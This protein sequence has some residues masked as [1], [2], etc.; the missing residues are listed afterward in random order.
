MKDYQS[1]PNLVV[2]PDNLAWYATVMINLGKSIDF[3]H[4]D[5]R[6]IR[7]ELGE[8]RTEMSE[9]KKGLTEV[10]SPSLDNLITVIEEK[11]DEIRNLE[12]NPAIIEKK[13]KMLVKASI[14][15]PDHHQPAKTTS[16]L[17]PLLKQ[18]REAEENNQS[19]NQ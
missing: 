16:P 14:P 18:M 10:Q 4:Q 12:L 5:L 19:E 6:E 8:I 9:I 15:T 1:L 3:L 17:T 11:L 13:L 7:S 2:T